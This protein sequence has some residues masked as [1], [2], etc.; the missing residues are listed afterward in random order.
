MR[1]IEILDK[2]EQQLF[3]S[4]KS[5]TTVD[6]KITSLYQKMSSNGAEALA[7]QRIWLGLFY[8]GDTCGAMGDFFKNLI[9]GDLILSLFARC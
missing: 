6:Q 7:R 9:L 3:D 2:E 1:K 4:P 5:L 8:C